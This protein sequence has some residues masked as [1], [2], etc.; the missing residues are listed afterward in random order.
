MGMALVKG[1]ELK[2]RAELKPLSKYASQVNT[3][4]WGCSG[5]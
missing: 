5:E 1:F 4:C 3:M 2:A